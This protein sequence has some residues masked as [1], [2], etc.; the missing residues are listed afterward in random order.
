MHP[1][2]IGRG[3][4]LAMLDEFI[5]YMRSVGG[6][7]FERMCDYAERWS[8]ANP[9]AEWAGAHPIETGAAAVAWSPSRSAGEE[10]Q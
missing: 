9:R 6:V 1:Q 4:R 8:T 3:G 5:G 7:T 10:T 2:V